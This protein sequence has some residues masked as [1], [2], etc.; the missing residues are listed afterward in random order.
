VAVHGIG[1][2]IG[3]STIQSV[4]VRV[5]AYYGIAPALPLGRF[6]SVGTARA[7]GRERPRGVLEVEP[8]P[9]LM[10]N[11]PDPVELADIGFAEVYWAPIARNLVERKYVLEE[12]RKWGRSIAA[13]V[14]YRG[15]KEHQWSQ[16]DVERLVTVIDQ[17]VHSVL[18][19]ERLTLVANKAG[20]FDFQLGK[21]LVDFVGDVQI[22]GDFEASRHQILETFHHVVV[23]TLALA[24]QRPAELYIV[25]HSE[26]SVVAFLALLHA[27]SDPERYPWIRQVRGV[28]TIGS[29]IEVHHLLWPEL[30]VAPRPPQPTL[31]P[32]P[33]LADSAPIEWHNYMDHGDPIAYELR[34][35]REWMAR[36][37]VRFDRHLQLREHSFSRSFVPG[38]AHVDYW[39]DD[40]VFG[41]FLEN[42]VRPPAPA[43]GS[44]FA[45][46]P[47]DRLLART[48]SWLLPQLS[49]AAVLMAAVYILYRPV[50]AAVA[51]EPTTA[52]VLRDVFSIGLLMLGVTATSR[53]PR[54]MD[55]WEWWL[56]SGVLLALAMAVQSQVTCPAT[57]LLV[58][59]PVADWLR[60]SPQ[61]LPTGMVE[62]YLSC[63][64]PVGADGTARLSGA[65]VAVWMVALGVAL[66]ASAAA[67]RYPRYGHIVLPAFGAVAAFALI[68]LG[69]WELSAA[70]TAPGLGGSEL[71]PVLLAGV[72][73]FYLW[74]LSAL[75]FDLVFVWQRYVRGAAMRAHLQR[76]SP[77]AGNRY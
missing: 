74:W 19:L 26:G 36:P 75:L 8:S 65:I 11:P 64:L 69:A 35:T 24:P 53:I 23:R 25:G 42:V 17:I 52:A 43:A 59:G 12:T 5:G 72:V 45:A 22:V 14:S 47:P 10:V 41:H 2:Q 56:F 66:G 32:S 63:G 28:M 48:T 67:W 7:D 40:H 73:F 27:L 18:V 50:A 37:D 21:L 61:W 57:Q 62:P 38:K 49:I 9:V 54:I 1:D 51:F 30:W 15:I 3:Y 31:T 71:W 4:A 33:A 39:N 76:L 20:V 77:H 29:P 60:L 6:Y 46:P 58:G 70:G 44:R 16:R 34:A 13:R 55:R 68:A